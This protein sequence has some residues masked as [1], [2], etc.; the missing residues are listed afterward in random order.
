V[1][2]K[3]IASGIL[4][5][6]QQSGEII[7]WQGATKI[8]SVL[9]FAHAARILG[10]EKFGISGMVLGLSV[11]VVAFSSLLNEAHLSRRFRQLTSDSGRQ[12]LI[13]AAFAGRLI[14]ALG[15]TFPAMLLGFW[16]APDPSW[17]LPIA[18][19]MMVALTGFLYAHWV[20]AGEDR[21]QMVWRTVGI[22]SLLT[23][24][25]LMVLPSFF[26][27]AGIDAIA[28]AA[29]GLLTAVL[30]WWLAL[31]RRKYRIR[32]NSRVVQHALVLVRRSGWL[33]LMYLAAN[34]Y[35][36]L[37]IFLL[38]L[39]GSPED[40]G[41][42]RPA[43]NLAASF[44][45]S[46]SFIP[47]LLFPKLLDW[48]KEPGALRQRQGQLFWGLLGWFVVTTFVAGVA[49]KPIFA[50]LYGPAYR[51][52]SAPFILLIAARSLGIVA[53]IFTWGLIARKQDRLVGLIF[54]A[55]A[56][57]AMLGNF[58]LIPRFGIWGPAWSALLCDGLIFVLAAW[59]SLAG[60][61]PNSG[62]RRGS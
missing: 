34:T 49:A 4:R 35:L 1:I 45:Q 6:I 29:G 13:N 56:A 2:Q 24:I 53:S 30:S 42:Y 62:G 21:L 47:L 43:G 59:Y 36:Y 7:F 58:V 37:D 9:A 55:G 31:G 18:G 51:D 54:V 27:L 22:G 26:P 25:L 40:A 15:L 14:L 60:N 12:S 11:Q 39:I 57:V 48:A 23:S 10:P 44:H 16:L 5:R 52:A 8:V 28:V 3:F 32:L 61:I 38:G 46:V 33:F 19:G 20:F 17:W 50:A 41:I